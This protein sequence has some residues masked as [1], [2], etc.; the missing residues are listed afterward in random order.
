MLRN[1]DFGWR[2]QANI[3]DLIYGTLFPNY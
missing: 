2:G 1:R 3:K